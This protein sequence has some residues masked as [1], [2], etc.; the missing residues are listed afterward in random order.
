MREVSVSRW[1]QGGC[2]DWWMGYSKT[3]R[4]ERK[5]WGQSW[6]TL[7]EP[8]TITTISL[9]PP[10]HQPTSITQWWPGGLWVSTGPRWFPSIAA[11]QANVSQPMAPM[12]RGFSVGSKHPHSSHSVTF[13]PDS[14]C[15][16]P[17]VPWSRWWQSVLNFPVVFSFGLLAL[18]DFIFNFKFNFPSIFARCCWFVIHSAF[19]IL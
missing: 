18:S 10:Y 9:I 2:R 7:S 14:L 17:T 3:H 4:W 13:H 12:G 8:S 5:A 6:H 19:P 16:C 15:G 11:I 1:C